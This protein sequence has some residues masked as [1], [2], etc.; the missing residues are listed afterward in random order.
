IEIHSA[1]RFGP[2]EGSLPSRERGL[3]YIQVSRNE[4]VAKVAPFTGAW[5]EIPSLP[6][7]NDIAA[8][9]L[10]SRERGLKSADPNEQAGRGQSLPSRERGLKSDQEFFQQGFAGRSLHGSVD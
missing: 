1:Q 2:T 8:E 7:A 4:T 5:I 9:S 3:K 10:P 6:D